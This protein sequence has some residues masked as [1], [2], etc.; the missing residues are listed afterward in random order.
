VP[1]LAERL[2]Y[3][4]STV[5]PDPL[6]D[7]YLAQQ[8]DPDA[9][10]LAHAD[11]I[12]RDILACNPGVFDY[13]MLA[14]PLA[15]EPDPGRV[16]NGCDL[17]EAPTVELSAEPVA[18]RGVQLAMQIDDPEVGTP[19]VAPIQLTIFW[20][21]GR[22][23]R[24]EAPA[25][26]GRVEVGHTY[27]VSGRYTVFVLA[28]NT[29]GLRGFAGLVVQSGPGEAGDAPGPII[30]SEVRLVDAV[31]R[32]NTLSGNVRRMF[33]LLDGHDQES[34][35][36]YRLGMSPAREITFNE[37][38][39]MGTV[40]GHNTGAAPVDFIILRPRWRDGFYTGFRKAFMRIGRLEMHVFDTTTGETR[41]IEVP[42]VPE[43]V[44][45]FV[46]EQEA[47]LAPED[48][49]VDEMG[50]LELFLH[51]RDRLTKRIEIDLPQP[52][53]IAGA[54]GPVDVP[55]GDG[56]WYEERPGQFFQ[57]GEVPP[58]A[59][60]GVADMDDAGMGDAG[61]MHAVGDQGP[62]SMDAQTPD[63]GTGGQP[64]SPDADEGG[65]HT[66]PGGPGNALW[67]LVPCAW[68]YRRK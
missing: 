24:L 11:P 2:R 29:S 20:G 15:D 33:F 55:D 60:M 7:A 49:V 31:A 3:V 21:D 4:D 28:E 65:C 10:F 30:V 8:P 51:D 43:A 13:R 34:D 18:P 23:D 62:P 41:A 35:E 61:D 66:A 12:V 63:A 19:H 38:T 59:D 6:R 45:I 17:G 1:A 46:H 5:W 39:P 26:Q 48:L 56:Q 36:F 25:G 64:G 42:L 22:V 52:L 37:D 58:M 32:A 50:R 9:A 54:P 44:R 57:V 16:F 68:G 53:L 40:V 27:P 67:F 47:P 14:V